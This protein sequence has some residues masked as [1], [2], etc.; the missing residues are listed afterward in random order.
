[1]ISNKKQERLRFGE[2]DFD[3]SSHKHT[4]LI[5]RD[6]FPILEKPAGASRGCDYRIKKC[7]IKMYYLTYYRMY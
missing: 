6:I 1:M 7:T 2:I 3:I 4:V 5:N